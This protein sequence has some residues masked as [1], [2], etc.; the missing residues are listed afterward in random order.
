MSLPSYIRYAVAVVFV[1]SFASP[2]GAQ[3]APERKLDVSLLFHFNQ[4]LVPSAGMASQVAYKGL[5]ATLRKHPETPVQIQISGTLLNALA[6]MDPRAIELVREGVAAGQF[7]IIGSTYSQNVMFASGDAWTND[8]QIATHRRLLQQHFDVEPV[9]FWNPERVWTPSFVELLAKNGYEYTFVEGHI[10][11]DSDAQAPLPVTRSTRSGDS[12]LAIIH[13]DQ[14]IIGL[15]DG[16]RDSG[17]PDSLLAY[18]RGLHEADTE[19]RFL[20]AYCQD[21]EASGLWQFER[22][23]DPAVTFANLDTLLTVLEHTDW[24]NVTTGRRFLAEHHPAEELSPILDGQATWMTRF[25]Q[26]LGFDDWYDYWKTDSLQAVF[27]PLLQEVRDSLRAVDRDLTAMGRPRAAAALFDRAVRTFLAH[28]YEF[29]A[30]WL[31]TRTWSDFRLATETYVGLLAVRHA[32]SPGETFSTADPNRDGVQEILV[33][34]ETDLFVF[35][36]QG[37]RL[38]YWFDLEHGESLVGNENATH[39]A[40]VYVDGNRYVPELRAAREAYPWHEARGHHP[41]IRDR[42][43]RLR[44]RALNDWLYDGGVPVDSLVFR[45]Y[46]V[47]FEDGSLTFRYDAGALELT[48]RIEPVADS[49]ID[50]AYTIRNRGPTAKAVTLVVESGFSPSYVNAMDHGRAALWYWDGEPQEQLNPYSTVGVINRNTGVVVHYL[51]HDQPFY[52]EGD[53]GLF[54]IEVNPRY[55]VRLAPGGEQVLRFGLRRRSAGE[56]RHEGT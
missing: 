42:T 36:P 22:G 1:T 9:G 11:E 56:P 32:L 46:D 27:R 6:W 41:E 37:G 18:L 16:A 3:H 15:F 48:K 12:E 45:T 38:L 53:E 43:Y 10:L 13:D 50:I 55:P 7:E 17:N 5:L 47:A 20:V 14:T 51:F 23:T 29:G 39:Y 26:T 40:E 35:S 31:W 24:L 19:D 52:V 33:A 34:G 44:R 4:D 25:A 49:G 21:A 30:S 2:V 28:E 54:A 8:R